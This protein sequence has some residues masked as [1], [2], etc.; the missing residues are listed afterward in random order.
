MLRLYLFLMNCTSG[1]V[2]AARYSKAATKGG[3]RPENGGD[4]KDCSF[5]SAGFYANLLII[6]SSGHWVETAL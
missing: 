6:N 1:I 5:L 2:P 4:G 3:T